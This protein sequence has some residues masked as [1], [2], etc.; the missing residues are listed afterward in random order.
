MKRT[1]KIGKDEKKMFI[2][3]LEKMAKV[4][5]FCVLNCKNKKAFHF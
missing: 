4:L 2:I 3:Y 5:K 1:A